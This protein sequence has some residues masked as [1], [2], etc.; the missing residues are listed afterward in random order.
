MI[1]ACTCIKE[2]YNYHIYCVTVRHSVINDCDRR[3]THLGDLDIAFVLLNISSKFLLHLECYYSTVIDIHFFCT[4][5]YC[6]T[7]ID[8]SLILEILNLLLCLIY[9]QNF[10]YI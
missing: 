1:N 8:V 2:M 9:L 4:M 10:F 7:A 3:I 6:I 5:I